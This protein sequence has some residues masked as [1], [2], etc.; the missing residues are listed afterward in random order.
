M[1]LGFQE[2]LVARELRRRGFHE[3]QVLRVL[4]RLSPE[5]VDALRDRLTRHPYGD[6]RRRLAERAAMAEMDVIFNELSEYELVRILAGSFE[7]GSLNS[8][9][10]RWENE[11]PQHEVRVPSFYLG[12][13]PVTNAQYALYLKAKPDAPE[14]AYWADRQFNQ[15]RQPVVGVSWEDAKAFARWAGLRPPSE[16]E[17]EYAC[18]AG[19]T[20]RFYTGSKEADLD[21]AGWYAG[22]LKGKPH[23]IGEIEPNAFGLYDLHGNVWEWVEDDY[24]EDYENAPVDGQA[25]IESPRG[26]YRV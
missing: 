2:Y 11:G 10:G 22:N 5:Q 21:R 3:P 8:E 1:H 26:T 16:A 23:P 20:T 4:E 6:I 7:M 14:L 9:E 15:P 12:R 25:W 19:T 24:H 13:Y 17:W 18:R